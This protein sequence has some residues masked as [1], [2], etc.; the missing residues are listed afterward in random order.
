[1]SAGSCFAK[2]GQLGFDFAGDLD[3]VAAGLLM[4]LENHRVVAVGSHADP[5]RRSPFAD[6]GNIVETNQTARDQ[7]E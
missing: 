4:D 5:L 1:M 3:S 6:R 2:P 7:N